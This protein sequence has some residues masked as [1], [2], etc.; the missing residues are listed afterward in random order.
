[1]RGPTHASADKSAAVAIVSRGTPFGRAMRRASRV[2]SST[3]IRAGH[4]AMMYSLPVLLVA[5]FVFE[6]QVPSLTGT[7]GLLS[8]VRTN[9]ALDGRE[10]ELKSTSTPANRFGAR[11]IIRPLF[12]TKEWIPSARTKNK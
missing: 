2:S 5:M 3:L 1:M 9:C 6:P 10:G 8:I 12:P 11:G 4:Q 7:G